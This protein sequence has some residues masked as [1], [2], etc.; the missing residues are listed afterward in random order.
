MLTCPDAKK[1]TV[2]KQTV[3]RLAERSIMPWFC[4][5]GIRRRNR[6]IVVLMRIMMNIIEGVQ[7]RYISHSSLFQP[8]CPSV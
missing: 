2:I 4:T 5:R 6:N 7:R 8:S 3:S 1:R